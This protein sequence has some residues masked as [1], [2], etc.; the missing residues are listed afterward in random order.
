MKV[1]AMTAF[2]AGDKEPF[3]LTTFVPANP[4]TVIIWKEAAFATL[5]TEI[6]SALIKKYIV[7]SVCNLIE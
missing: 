6:L 7:R 1:P 5:R 4:C 3:L 2:T